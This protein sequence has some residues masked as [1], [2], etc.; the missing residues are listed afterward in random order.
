MKK[1]ILI[2]S[3]ILTSL[4]SE[5]QL[6]IF[7]SSTVSAT[8]VLVAARGIT[9]VKMNI[10]NPSATDTDY[11]KVYDQSTAPTYTSTPIDT[12]YQILPKQQ[13]YLNPVSTDELYSTIKMYLRCTKGGADTS[14]L[15][16][17]IKPIITINYR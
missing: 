4:I 16:P 17:A 13:I 1:T 5:A 6:G 8:G 11:V 7:H 14:Q 3:M 12:P 9:V 2:L 15:V 10:Y